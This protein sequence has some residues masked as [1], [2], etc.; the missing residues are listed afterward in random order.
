MTSCADLSM[1][2]LISYGYEYLPSQLPLRVVFRFI[3]P[4]TFTCSDIKYRPM[5]SYLSLQHPGIYGWRISFR[6]W[7]TFMRVSILLY[8]FKS[9]GP[10]SILNCVINCCNPS[11]QQP[12][13]F[14]RDDLICIPAGQFADICFK[15]LLQRLVLCQ[16]YDR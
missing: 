12:H 14:L 16:P 2:L 11:C 4:L 1:I 6:R 5:H 3:I 10:L 7:R 15:H 13:Y 9:N 8:S